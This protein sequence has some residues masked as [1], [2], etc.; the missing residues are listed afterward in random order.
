MA[1]ANLALR[2][3]LETA[4]FIGAGYVAYELADGVRGLARWLLAVIATLAVIGLWGL[5]AAPRR[6]NGLTQAQKDV[7]GS[8]LLVVI[9]IAVALAGLGAI[10]IGFA[11][12]VVVNAML[13]FVFGQDA[14]ARLESR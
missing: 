5:L 10:G 1:I 3:L 14:R 12:L 13:L 2:F 4:G 11:A 6:R 9:A 8:I 7:I